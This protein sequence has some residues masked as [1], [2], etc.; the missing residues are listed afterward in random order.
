[1]TAASVGR[2]ERP[3]M[4]SFNAII[5]EENGI[6]TAPSPCRALR[7]ENTTAP[8]GSS[9]YGVQRTTRLRAKAAIMKTVKLVKDV[10]KLIRSRLIPSSAEAD[11]H[12]SFDDKTECIYAYRG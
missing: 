5:V 10:L 6:G 11:V 7:K 4:S 9:S 8:S 12:R 1:M 2:S 3:K